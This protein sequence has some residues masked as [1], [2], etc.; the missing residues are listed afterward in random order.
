MSDGEVMKQILQRLDS[1]EAVL[2]RRPVKYDSHLMTVAEAA[3]EFR[4]APATLYRWKDVQVRVG[5]TIRISR[6]L[7]DAKTSR[8]GRLD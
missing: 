1:I 2:Y 8:P 3:K 4:L 6:E 5:N 7:M